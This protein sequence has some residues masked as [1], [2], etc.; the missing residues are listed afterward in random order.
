[1]SRASQE[2]HSVIQKTGSEPTR[3]LTETVCGAPASA[4][5]RKRL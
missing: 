5:L 4:R 1:M 3:G 2:S